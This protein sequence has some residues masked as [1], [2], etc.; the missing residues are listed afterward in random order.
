MNYDD[1]Y[2]TADGFLTQQTAEELRVTIQSYI[3]IT[4]YLL[5]KCNFSYV[6][7]SKMNQDNLE[8]YNCAHIF[9]L[10]NNNIVKNYIYF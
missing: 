9:N 5:D 2:I 7:A 8:V 10:I 3:D 6:L 1:G 4:L